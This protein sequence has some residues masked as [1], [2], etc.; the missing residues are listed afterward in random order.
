MVLSWHPSE[1]H[2]DTRW[3][4]ILTPQREI[5]ITI[6]Y[7]TYNNTI[8]Q[9]IKGHLYHK[10]S[11]VPMQAHRSFVRVAEIGVGLHGDEAIYHK[12]LRLRSC[13][14]IMFHHQP[15]C[16]HHMQLKGYFVFAHFPAD[17]IDLR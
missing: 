5:T 14:K 16:M 6:T 3:V 17:L 15:A 1:I 7:T 10:V 8:Q 11:H 9:I 4:F 2:D 12:A 13:Q